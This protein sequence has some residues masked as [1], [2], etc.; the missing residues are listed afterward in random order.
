M[1]SY[2]QGNVVN[3]L[4]VQGG[5]FETGDGRIL[6][7]AE[8]GSTQ[9][10]LIVG[11]DWIWTRLGYSAAV[12]QTLVGSTGGNMEHSWTITG[13]QQ[14]L[15]GSGNP[16]GNLV[17][18]I[19]GSFLSTPQA[20]DS[21]YVQL[22]GQQQSSISNNSDSWG[23]VTVSR[24]LT[25]A[26]SGSASALMTFGSGTDNWG[27]LKYYLS[28]GGGGG[29][30]DV[31]QQ[32]HVYQFSFWAMTTADGASA[33]VSLFQGDNSNAENI[34]LIADGQWHQYALTVNASNPLVY[35]NGVGMISIH[36]ANST[37]HV[38]DVQIIDLSDQIAPGNRLSK[39]AVDLVKQYGFSTLRFWNPS[40]RFACL[41]DLIGDPA[42]R[43]MI[44]GP[45]S[46]Y[47]PQLGLPEMLEL[48]KET[49]TTA[50]IVVP[51]TWSAQEMHD[52]MEYL[53]GSVDTVYGA[54]RAA[55]GHPGSWF[56]DLPGIKLEAGNESW[57]G[58]F[59]PNAY[60][61]SDIYFS[62]AQDMFHAVKTDPLYAAN[63]SGIKL[64][65]NGW[66]SVPWYTEQAIAKVPDADA[67][68]VSAYTGG[69]TQEAPINQILAGV[70][71][72]PM[73]DDAWN[74]PA[75]I[76]GDK[77]VYVYEEN[78]GLLLGTVTPATESAYATSLGA[79][80]A[81]IHNAMV[82]TRDYGI[83]SQNLFTM[84]Q[85]GLNL[86]NGYAL[87]HYGIFADMS[88]AQTNPRP[89]ALAARL[90]NQAGGEVLSSSITSGWVVDSTATAPL[91][92]TTQAADAMVTFDGKN[93]V[94]TMFN[95]TI[96]DTQNTT[97]HFN[98]PAMLD[99]K[100]FSVDWTKA[101]FNVLTG[102]SV[103]A[104]NEIGDEVS[105]TTGQ[106]SH[107]TRQVYA[108]LAGHSM[109]SLVIPVS[110]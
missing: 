39:E 66:Q 95:D 106:Y 102:P 60:S 11:S 72:Q 73:A 91:A 64:I 14:Q 31:L 1:T 22:T 75:S 77:Q 34:P 107:D 59:A 69:P 29:G 56:S 25:V 89:I 94:I 28:A 57:N 23:N 84:F 48:A 5:G 101:A 33:S 71:P 32:G 49:D 82:L 103:S 16:T 108:A 8:N 51:T 41:D 53:G 27:N 30:Q 61:G 17:I 93:L 40:L 55:D 19:Q 44:T 63:A 70:L 43:P 98:L 79:G 42:G 24:D 90:L 68:D 21:F 104:N 36:S 78:A 54:K 76:F 3:E 85:Q 87:G 12:G 9:Q 46:D 50:W 62:R 20:S 37:V 81:V 97:F 92:T 10:Q 7:Q 105:I 35:G 65:A 26:H 45:W 67:V 109:G 18:T 99:G 47:D 88:S 86:P 80:L 13:M 38:D 15:D 2:A 58:T 83:C 100:A 74:F 52:L 96:A 4:I 6:V 110:F